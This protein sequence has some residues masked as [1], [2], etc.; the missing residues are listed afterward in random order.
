MLGYDSDTTGGTDANII[1][2][3]FHELRYLGTAISPN[4][5]NVL[6][7]FSGGWITAT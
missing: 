1:P 4:G 2:I 5:G 7:D 3:S 6:I